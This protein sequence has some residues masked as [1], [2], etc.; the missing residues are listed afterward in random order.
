[1]N[2]SDS[3]VAEAETS[4]SC[5]D[6]L[7]WSYNTETGALTIAGTGDM[8]NFAY[9]GKIWGGNDIKSVSLP[10][11]LTSIG[12][13]AFR[14]CTSLASVAIPSSV[15]SIGTSAFSGCTSLTSVAIPDSVESLGSFAF[16][17]CASLRT[18]NLSDNLE[19]LGS[20]TFFDCPSLTSV[21]IPDSVTSIENHAF[22]GCTSLTSVAIPD[23]VKTLGSYVFATCEA[24]RAIQF[25]T[26]LTSVG[27]SAVETLYDTDGVTE[28]PLSETAKLAGSAFLKTEDKFVKIETGIIFDGSELKLV[29]DGNSVSFT[30]DDLAYMKAIVS[31]DASKTLA[32]ETSKGTARFDGKAIEGLSAGD[33]KI[34]SVETATLDEATKNLVGDSPVYDISFGTNTNFGE[35][36]A[37]FTLSY[38]LPEGKNASELKV[39]YIKD[40]AIAE[41]IDVTY[42]D[43]NVTFSSNHLSMYSFGFE[44]SSSGS[45]GNNGGEFPIWIVAVIAVVAIAAVGGAFFFMQQKKKA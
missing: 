14:N 21:T 44:E 34:D 13:Y 23:S 2:D 39:Y 29:S 7:T 16:S 19:T 41:K 18:V 5:G 37:T 33:L 25:G 8:T 4:G 10:E 22:R 3:S 38:T 32:M 45:S 28:I 24:L 43:G 30:A 12:T 11:G 6:N 35:G 9:D 17:G 31:G 40:G 20:Y 1:M 15:N 27:I 42:A 26:G 36:K